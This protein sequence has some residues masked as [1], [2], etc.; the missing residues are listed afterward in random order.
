[1]YMGIL[2]NKIDLMIVLLIFVIGIISLWAFFKSI[3]KLKLTL[4]NPL[5]V[6]NLKLL[7][8]LHG[9]SYK[10][11]VIHIFMLVLVAIMVLDTL[12]YIM[13]F[14]IIGCY[15]IDI[16]LIL[17]AVIILLVAIIPLSNMRV[18]L[19]KNGIFINKLYQWNY[20]K[21]YVDEG[22]YIK[23]QWG[24]GISKLIGAPLYLKK[25]ERVEEIIKY[26]LNEI[27]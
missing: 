19:Y 14:P 3:K 20:F 12:L 21:G 23:L 18:E 11:K 2:L 24:K 4:D 15:P 7:E 1:M 13:I 10:R 22:E 17:N 25:N 9:N 26:Y 5:Y 8:Y 27:K 6:V 16:A